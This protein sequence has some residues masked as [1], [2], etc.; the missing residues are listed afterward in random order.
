MNLTEYE[1]WYRKRYRRTSSTR[2]TTFMI[3]A[4][5]IA[6]IFSFGVGFFLVNLYDMS[7]INF[8]SFVNYWPYLPIFI[9]VFWIAGRL[10][11]GAAQAPAEELRRF[12]E[13]SAI[14]HGG[15]IISRYIEDLEF[16]A[17]SMAFILSFI[18]SALILLV[19]RSLMRS[20]LFVTKLGSIPAVV[21]GGGSTG[22]VIIDRLL[23]SK[24]TGY[25]PV[26]ILDDDPSAEDEYRGI[27]VI[28]DTCI[29]PEIAALFHIR[30][31]LVALPE[32]SKK[33]LSVLINNSV[34]AFR[35]RVIIPAVFSNTGMSVR[36]FG[37]ILGI[38]STNR[39]NMFW[40]LWIKRLFDIVLV[41][42]GGIIILPFLLVT[43]LLVKLSSP[44]PVLYGHT[45]IGRGGRCFKAYKFR[46]MCVDADERLKAL[47]ESNPLLHEEWEANHK[48]KD[49]P[50]I[51]PIGKLLRRTSLDEFPQLIN[52][53]KGEM[54]L[55][56]P[57]PIVDAERKKYGEHFHRIFSVRPGLTGLWQVSGRSDTDYAERVSLDT[58]YLESWSLWLDFWI[59][60]KTVGAVIRGKG[61]Y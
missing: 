5:L 2:Y 42:G 59:L 1:I 23:Q 40:N 6:L 29:G 48:L 15:I 26:L 21:F 11:P 10:Y 49:D 45:R 22:R 8:R 41:L 55:I 20:F 50:R 14:V 33:H 31:A 56:G 60:Y 30:M 25:T 57:R 52:I 24:T 58:Y 61:A 37:G 46:S 43:A 27:P 4:D 44:G 18:F 3:I 47:L 12:T 19:C 36:D 28:H 38:A 51:T 9:L 7:A 54:S 13:T 17:I 16:D 53:L 32:L 35:Y 34:S 39:L